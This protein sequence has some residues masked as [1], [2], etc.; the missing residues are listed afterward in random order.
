MTRFI[1]PITTGGSNLLSQPFPNLLII[2]GVIA[3]TLPTKINPVC[4]AAIL[5][6]ASW[7]AI[8]AP[9]KATEEPKYT[10]TL[11]LVINE[12]VN[13]PTPDVNKVIYGR[14]LT[15]IAIIIVAEKIANTCRKLSTNH[16]NNVGVSKTSSNKPLLFIDLPSFYTFNYYI[17]NNIKIS[18]SS[19]FVSSE[20]FLNNLKA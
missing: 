1:G 13:V 10:G 15:V 20:D 5:P 2:S 11:A 14:I 4:E 19:N 9:T 3:H 17:F 16:K 18:Y 6:V 8:I 7:A 12:E